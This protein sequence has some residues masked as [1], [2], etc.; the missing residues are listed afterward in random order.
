[1]NSSGSCG[2]TLHRAPGSTR[3]HSRWAHPGNRVGAT[4]CAPRPDAAP[5]PEASRATHRTSCMFHLLTE[6]RDRSLP[7]PMGDVTAFSMFGD[8]SAK[9]TLW[10]GA[11]QPALRPT[12]GLSK[13]PPRLVSAWGKHESGWIDDFSES[14][15]PRP[16][17]MMV[18]AEL[19]QEARIAQ[20]GSARQG[21]EH[22]LGCHVSSPPSESCEPTARS[23]ERRPRKPGVRL[24]QKF[25]KDG[26]YWR[27]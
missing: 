27:G 17:R 3:E 25:H 24:S 22:P 4:L 18:G 20:N 8:H 7:L 16:I 5:D 13:T 10:V 12:G 15:V 26:K 2:L 14:S 19:P 11:W 21:G 9:R 6:T 1:V 23:V